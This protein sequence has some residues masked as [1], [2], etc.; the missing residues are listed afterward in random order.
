MFNRGSILGYMGEMA[1][2]SSASVGKGAR[3]AFNE[4]PASLQREGRALRNSRLGLGV[5][6]GARAYQ[7]GASRSRMVKYGAPAAGIVA[8]TSVLPLVPVVPNVPG[9]SHPA[10]GYNGP[11]RVRGHQYGNV[12]M[13]GA[14]PRSI[15]GTTF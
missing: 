4:A 11:S 15:G 3:Q 1:T 10:Y 13:N 12:T 8:A 2:R 7:R 9:L 6:R 14:A 5:E